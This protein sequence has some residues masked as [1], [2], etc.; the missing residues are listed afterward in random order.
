MDRRVR[1]VV[2]AVFAVAFLVSAPL[3]VLY[4]A[5]FRVHFPSFRVVRTGVL[6]V[7]SIPRGAEVFVDGKRLA[8][9]TPVVISDIL[10]GERTVRLS[11]E[12]S[13]PWEKTVAIKSRETAFIRDAVLYADEGPQIFAENASAA[14]ATDPARRQLAYLVPS[15]AGSELWLADAERG[16]TT[17]LSRLPPAATARVEWSPDARRVALVVEEPNGKTDVGVVDAQTGARLA[18]PAEAADATDGW[19]DPRRADRFYARTKTALFAYDFPSTRAQRLAFEAQAAQADGNDFFAIQDVDKGGVALSR[20]RPDASQIIAYL[21]SGEYVFR[22][23][24]RS[25]LLL[26]E[27]RTRGRLILI[28]PRNEGQPVM[29]DADADSWQWEP[30][31]ARLLYTDGFDIRIYDPEIGSEETLTRLSE[32]IRSVAWHP[33]AGAILFAQN[34][35]IASLELESEGGRVQAELVRGAFL[36][37]PIVDPRGRMLYFFGAVAD[38]STGIFQRVLQK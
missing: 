29:L 25:D 7:T 19:W 23:T 17:L 14:L 13:L 8:D 28:S 38:E 27:E 10:P 18:L 32:P 11:R 31:G 15:A 22:E 16:A 26:L 24:P 1:N 36:T 34:R 12:D 20:W 33:V 35:R 37:L 2:Y 9:R 21:P 4:T 5:G 3:V 6:S 30:D